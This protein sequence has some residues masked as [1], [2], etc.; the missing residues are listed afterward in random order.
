MA[1]RQPRNL[2]QLRKGIPLGNNR[3]L[4]LCPV[5][6]LHIDPVYQRSEI[7]ANTDKIKGRDFR[8]DAL[9][10]FQVGRRKKGVK[11][12]GK[13]YVTDG[14]HRRQAII[15]R[16]Q[17]GD[18]A[19]KEVLCVVTL[20][21]TQQQEAREFVE[22]N[23]DRPVTGNSRIKARFAYGARPETDIVRWIRK[24]GFEPDFRSAGSPS[25]ADREGNGIYSL[26]VLQK[27]YNRCT[28]HIHTALQFI[29]LVYG[30]S[31]HVPWTV[32]SGAAIAGIARFF[33]DSPEK[34]PKRVAKR[35]NAL[36]L[37]LAAGISDCR[38][39]DMKTSASRNA[40][41]LSRVIADW[42]LGVMGNGSRRKAA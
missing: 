38:E 24:E 16:I 18:P 6:K 22:N 39:E 8:E 26:Y 14:Q 21:T 10:I 42:L 32:R 13:D 19:P 9:G 34:D 3:I 11:G 33:V 36:A 4:Q 7:P 29:R 28:T 23:T 12:G 1:K 37:D 40:A 41:T 35:F 25:D 20:D 2:V 30:K 17:N 15:F 31:Q 27:S 5:E